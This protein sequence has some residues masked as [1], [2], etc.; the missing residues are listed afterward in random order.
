MGTALDD[1]R[2][3][4]FATPADGV[5]LPGSTPR[6]TACWR[7]SCHRE[8][9][10]EDLQRAKTRMIADAVYAQDSQVSLARWYGEALAT[11]LGVA[12]VASWPDRIDAVTSDA[13]IE[14]ARKWLDK[15]RS[16][17]RLSAAQGNGRR[18]KN[19]ARSPMEHAHDRSQYLET[20]KSRAEN[21]QRVITPGGIE[22]WLVESYAVPLV[23]LEISIR[24]GGAPGSGGQGRARDDV[25]GLA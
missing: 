13:I 23:A 21:V 8:L 2:L 22:A 4:V 11:G 5:E 9:S 20:P 14:A 6:S 1:T 7:D 10:S 25:R 15:K 24:C 12:D 18:L 17:D 16:V 3:Y 19:L